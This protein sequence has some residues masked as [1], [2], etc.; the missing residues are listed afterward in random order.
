MQ[1]EVDHVKNENS[2]DSY[3]AVGIRA[4]VLDNPAHDPSNNVSLMDHLNNELQ[5]FLNFL[6]PSDEEMVLRRLMVKRIKKL[7]LSGLRQMRRQQASA[8][9]NDSSYNVFTENM[10]IKIA[11]ALQSDAERRAEKSDTERCDAQEGRK[12]P[13][14]RVKCIGSYATGLYLAGGDTD[15]SLLT[16]EEDALEK[17]SHFLRKSPLILRRSVIFI[18]KARVPILR[19]VDICHFKYDLS[20]NQEASLAHTKFVK[21]ILHKQ[22]AIKDMALFLKQFLKCRG[23]NE[24]RRGGLNSYA[25]L[26]MIIS[27]LNL[28]PLVQNQVSIK[29]NLSVLFMDFFEFY[30]QDFC[31]D[32]AAICSSGYKAKTSNSYLSIEDPTNSSYDVGCLST[33]MNV[34]KEVFM[35]AYKTMSALARERVGDKYIALPLWVKVCDSEAIWRDNIPRFYKKMIINREI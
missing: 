21:D 2:D 1:N 12:R 16:E 10:D 20:L 29:A 26:L 8:S 30:G 31:Y 3:S 35:H 23:L 5:N 32:K 4:F 28:H 9:G 14:N 11:R 18:S 33:K 17:L 24:N 22:P 13:G 15:L 34:I 6:R 19:F 27:F 25:Q 7:I